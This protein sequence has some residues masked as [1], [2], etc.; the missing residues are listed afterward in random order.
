MRT[1]V[2]DCY[3]FLLLLYG[4]RLNSNGVLKMTMKSLKQQ[5]RQSELHAL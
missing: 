1:A 5:K 2:V 3:S 4:S